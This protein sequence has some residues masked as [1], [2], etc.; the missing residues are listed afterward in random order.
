MVPSLPFLLIG[1]LAAAGVAFFVFV[2]LVLKRRMTARTLELTSKGASSEQIIQ[3][4]VAEGNDPALSVQVVQRVIGRALMEKGASME[5]ARKESIAIP[6]GGSPPP[7][8]RTYEDRLP[9]DRVYY[10]LQ[11]VSL[12]ELAFRAGQPFWREAV[13]AGKI[14]EQNARYLW[15]KATHTAVSAGAVPR[16][17][18]MMLSDP[19]ARMALEAGA[20]TIADVP[21]TPHQRDGYTAWVFEMPP[22]K[23]A[24]DAHFIAAVIRDEVPQFPAGD[25]AGVHYFLLEAGFLKPMLCERTTEGR[26]VNHGS[27]PTLDR[28]AFASEVLGLAGASH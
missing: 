15:A 7:R 1:L 9:A 21:V 18:V 8:G 19:A 22:P 13:E 6:A 11:H 14:G 23:F 25:G 27:R 26:H 5:S 24:G 28:D 10:S 17:M 3:Q 4:L 20:A 12:P 16:E 2:D